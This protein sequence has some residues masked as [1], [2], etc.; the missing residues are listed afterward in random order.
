MGAGWPPYL[1]GQNLLDLGLEY[2]AAKKIE[3]SRGDPLFCGLR[4]LLVCY[5]SKTEQLGLVLCFE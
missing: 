5:L 1:R 2:I 4:R 3:V